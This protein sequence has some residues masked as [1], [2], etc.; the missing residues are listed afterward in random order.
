MLAAS[1]LACREKPVHERDRLGCTRGMMFAP[2][3]QRTAGPADL[4][5]VLP[6]AVAFYAEDAFS[7]GEHVLRRVDQV[8]RVVLG[9]LPL[10]RRRAAT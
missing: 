1:N 10:T 4:A 3:I 9:R 6:L 2:V 7:T 8:T 5:A